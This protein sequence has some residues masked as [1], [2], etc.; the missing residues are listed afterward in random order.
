MSTTPN[1]NFYLPVPGD[2]RS[3]SHP[4]GN[5][6]NQNFTDI[7]TQLNNRPTK[8]E[9][10]LKDTTPGSDLIGFVAPYTGAVVR[11]QTDKNL[12]NVTVRDLAMK[13][14]STG[15][16][17]S[18]SG[19]VVGSATDNSPLLQ[20]IFDN[21]QIRN[22]RVPAGEYYL[23]SPVRWELGFKATASFTGNSMTVTLTE[24]VLKIGQFLTFTGQNGTT[25]ITGQTS[26]TTGAAG[27]YTIDQAVSSP[28]SSRYVGVAAVGSGSQILPT[29]RLSL[30]GVDKMDV[31]MIYGGTGYAFTLYTDGTNIT[32]NT[33]CNFSNT[34]WV[35]SKWDNS[36]NG[37]RFHSTSNM[38]IDNIYCSGF[39]VGCTFEGVLSSR[40]SNSSFCYN[41]NGLHMEGIG[42]ITACNAVSF[43][44]CSFSN[45]TE[46]GFA[47]A[48]IGATL[49]FNQCRFEGNGIV[50][51]NKGGFYGAFDGANGLAGPT[52]IGCYFEVNTGQADMWIENDSMTPMTVTLIGCTFNRVNN[53]NFTTCNIHCSSPGGGLVK[54]VL[55]GC[56]F[57]SGSGYTPGIAHPFIVH[58]NNC[59][60][61]DIGCCWGKAGTPGPDMVGLGSEAT[62]QYLPSSTTTAAGFVASDGTNG[63][64]PKNSRWTSVRESIGSY[65]LTFNG[66]QGWGTMSN[67]YL[68]Q[69]TAMSNSNLV[70]V[71]SVQNVSATQFR[72]RTGLTNTGAL[73]DSDF[74][75]T[76]IRLA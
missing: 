62:F 74:N 60:V 7:D 54:V 49:T 4:W 53:T 58:D 14:D 24:G 8:A 71:L 64:G 50:G 36:N 20:A 10:H 39:N 17:G 63:V 15:V 59:E 26:G 70:T 35:C 40:V 55:V 23:A 1:F 72:V 75:W 65:L 44:D 68:A 3:N 61:I 19:F 5:Q 76:C 21:G 29:R 12:D 30:R 13:G 37:P 34:S 57:L 28:L 69:A 6:I 56:A 31:R 16:I 25:K 45:N 33:F 22:A 66:N 9:L 27:T 51:G 67:S 46:W 18:P 73:S 52:F 11:T 42:G 43:N 48:S 47:G 32:Q 41:T 2:G 38:E